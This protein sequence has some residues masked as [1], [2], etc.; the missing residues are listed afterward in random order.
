[1]SVR[2]FTYIIM[3]NLDKNPIHGD[4]SPH[5]INKQVE[6]QRIGDLPGSHRHSFF[7][8]PE[9]W[10]LLEDQGQRKRR[11]ES[12]PAWVCLGQGSSSEILGASVSPRGEKS[13]PRDLIH[14]ATLTPLSA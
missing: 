2:G 3:F 11:K 1:M 14:S 10:D 6:A 13:W 7:T 8:A 12:Q 5:F 4:Y 9:Q